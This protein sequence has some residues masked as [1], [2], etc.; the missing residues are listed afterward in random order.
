[1]ISQCVISQMQ[2]RGE[3]IRIMQNRS[4]VDDAEQLQVRRRVIGRKVSGLAARFESGAA[5]SDAVGR[6]NIG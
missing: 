4:V 6:P 3:L 5:R 2:I 1:M